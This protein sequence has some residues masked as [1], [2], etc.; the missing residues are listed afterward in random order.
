VYCRPSN[1]FDRGR[2]G[3]RYQGVCTGGAEADFLDAYNAGRMLYDLESALHSIDSRIVGNQRA[4]ENIKKELVDIA[5]TIALDDTSPD[6]RVRLVADAAQLGSRYSDIENET[7][8]LREERVVVALD[9][10]DYRVSLSPE[11]VARAQ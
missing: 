1:G 7:K 10:A 4:Q 3:S 5:A 11:W 2:S 9:L 6:E 8:A